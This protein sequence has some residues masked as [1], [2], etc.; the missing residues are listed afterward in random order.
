LLAGFG[1]ASIRITKTATIT[2][3]LISKEGQS[4]AR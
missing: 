1:L 4:N 3:L 2:A